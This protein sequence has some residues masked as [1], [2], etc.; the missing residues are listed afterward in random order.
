MVRYGLFIHQRAGL[1]AARRLKLDSVPLSLFA[2]VASV[3][4]A[5]G[6]AK[7]DGSF[8]TKALS[9]RA[10]RAIAVLR[11][12]LAD[13]MTYRRP[14]YWE[15]APEIAPETADALAAAGIRHVAVDLSCDSFGGRRPAGEGRIENANGDFRAR[16]HALG[17]LVTENCA[18]LSAL[19]QEEAFFFLAPIRGDGLTTAPCRPVALTEWP[20]DAPAI[21]DVSTPL[22]N[23]WR[24]KLDIDKTKSFE[25]GDDCEETHFVFSGHGFTH[26]DAPRHMERDGPSMQELPNGGLDLFLRS[27][28]IADFS[29]LPLPTPLTRELIS[30]RVGKV[31]PGTII[32]LRSDLTNRMGYGSNRWHLVAPNLEVEAAEWLAAQ[33]PAAIAL[34]F[35][36]DFVARQMPE[37]HVYNREF[38]AHHAILGQGIPFIED[39]RDIGAVT[40]DRPFLAAVPL[41]MN[42]PDGAPMRVLMLDWS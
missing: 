4:A 21:F 23:H 8:V 38:V 41:R 12:G 28:K 34:D 5:D 29:D 17:L 30:S 36:Q 7:I 33:Q 22:M 3:V 42:C 14:Q 31:E 10:P 15:N 27:A 35:P 16:C 9:G 19:Q 1:E 37:R 26:C 24:W 40:T 39:L 25:K 32:V 6:Q 11:T 20:K 2:G 18:N 13:R